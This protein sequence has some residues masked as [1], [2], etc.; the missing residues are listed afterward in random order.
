MALALWRMA[1]C[2]FIQVHSVL[3][4]K[5]SL[6][7]LHLKVSPSI[8]LS[9]VSPI[10]GTLSL[11]FGQTSFVIS[12]VDVGVILSISSP[13]CALYHK[14]Y[15]KLSQTFVFLRFFEH[16]DADFIMILPFLTSNPQSSASTDFCSLLILSP[17]MYLRT[18]FFS[19]SVSE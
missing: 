18:R 7:R 1:L 12:F 3:T 17:I 2:I 11:Q 14:S 10:R 15:L 19:A 16:Y 9:F 13:L 8:L 6:H 4:E 5:I